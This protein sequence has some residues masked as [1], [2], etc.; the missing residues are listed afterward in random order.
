MRHRISFVLRGKGN[1]AAGLDHRAVRITIAGLLTGLLIGAVGGGFRLLLGNADD[2]RY[3]L[4][5]PTNNPVR[6]ESIDV[7]RLSLLSSSSYVPSVRFGVQHP[8]LLLP[9]SN[10][11]ASRDHCTSPPDQCAAAVKARSCSPE[12]GRSALLDLA[13]AS[14]AWLALGPRHRET[15]NRD[16]L[17]SRRI[18]AVMDLEEPPCE[19][20]TT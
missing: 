11:P 13:A 8:R 10:G 6:I 16:P 17:A 14:L 15:G 2:L 12:S 19:A 9:D 18:P 20:R 1:T 3:A 7:A 5:V 4:V